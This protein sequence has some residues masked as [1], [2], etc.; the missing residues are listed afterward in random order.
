MALRFLELD[1]AEPNPENMGNYRYYYGKRHGKQSL[2]WI[3]WLKLFL[4]NPIQ[5]LKLQIANPVVLTEKKTIPVESVPVAK[6]SKPGEIRTK[7][8]REK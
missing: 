7:R 1:S 6:S 5:K 8:T 2:H 3:T 4:Q